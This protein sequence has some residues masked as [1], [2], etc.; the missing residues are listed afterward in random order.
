[1]YDLALKKKTKQIKKPSEI[2]KMYFLMGFTA[3]AIRC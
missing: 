1:M 2:L 3:K